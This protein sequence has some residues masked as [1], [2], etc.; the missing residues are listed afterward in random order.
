VAAPIRARSLTIQVD[1]QRKLLDA[2]SPLVAARLSKSFTR[3]ASCQRAI[4]SRRRDL[5]ESQS[6]Q[7]KMQAIAILQR[8]CS[9]SLLTASQ[10]DGVFGSDRGVRFGMGSLVHPL[11]KRF[12]HR[13]GHLSG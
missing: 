13:R 4:S 5:K 11:K 10:V 8:S 12:L 3:R 7:T 9:D 2:F 1:C 6:T